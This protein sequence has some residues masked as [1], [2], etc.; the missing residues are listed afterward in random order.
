MLLRTL[1]VPDGHGQLHNA[2]VLCGFI[3]THI[4]RTFL[5]YSLNEKSGD[6]LIKIYLTPLEGDDRSLDMCNAP[7]EALTTAT[8]VLKSIIRDAC[9]V[10]ATQTDDTYKVMDLT[11]TNILCSAAN[12]HYSLKI[13]E[14]WLNSL[15]QYSPGTYEN[16]PSFQSSGGHEPERSETKTESVF[17]NALPE[18]THEQ[19]TSEKI[20]VNLKSLIASVVKHKEILLGKYIALEERERE[21]ERREKFLTD[22]ELIM[23]QREKELHRSIESLQ[24]AEKQ[25]NALLRA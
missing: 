17:S 16:S 5:V 24:S 15:L 4:N 23:S 13:S 10:D 1:E 2:V 8:Q 9:S 25:L 12:T 18:P 6:D 21:C 14:A 19:I 20:E 11:E 3:A 22:Q 7:P